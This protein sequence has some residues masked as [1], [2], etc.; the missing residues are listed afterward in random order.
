[1]RTDGAVAG[2]IAM[3]LRVLDY[4]MTGVQR[5]AT[6]IFSRWQ[7]CRSI[8]PD[9]PISG[10]RGHL[11]EQMVLPSRLGD[12]LLFS[13]SNTGPLAVSNQVVTLHDVVPLDHP[14]WLSPTFASWYR[15]LIPKLVRNV[16][17]VITISEFSKSRILESTGIDPEKISVI[18]NGV[19][20]RFYPRGA[21]EIEEMR[22][23]LQLPSGPYILSLGTLEPRKNLASL[24]RAWEQ[25]A[26]E[27]ADDVWLV[28]AGRQG[29]GNIFQQMALS[30]SVKRV[31]ACGHVPDELLPALYS[32]ALAFAY[33]SSYEGFGLP[34]L[35]AMAAGAPVI[36][37]NLTALP[38]VV[39]EC[40]LMV[41]PFAVDVIADALILMLDNPESRN[42]FRTKGLERAQC[43]SW[44]ETAAATLA[45]L[46]RFAEN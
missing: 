23:Q 30:G 44:R 29:A 34:P 16:R 26:N 35:E 12:S 37:G 45:L 6:E 31:H 41:D 9:S 20:E 3:N 39:G 18:P 1:M 8:R 32:G 17:H 15:T 21:A 24:V 4:P 42:S 11:W 36:T 5:Y 2:R 25:I 28:I 38:E 46:N 13:P 10:I 40:G 33:L 43:F 19:D 27:T 22:K 14:E 7:D